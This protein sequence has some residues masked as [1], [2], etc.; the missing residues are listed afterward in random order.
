M[1]RSNYAPRRTCVRTRSSPKP[2][3]CLRKTAR[4]PKGLMF[5]PRPCPYVHKRSTGNTAIQVRNCCVVRVY[6]GRTAAIIIIRIFFFP[7]RY[8]TASTRSATV[9]ALI[10]YFCNTTLIS[11][12]RSSG[13]AV[14]GR[15]IR[16][17]VIV[18]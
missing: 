9:V 12:F 15:S 13:R 2:D 7:P 6:R 4:S 17:P 18:H 8:I 11:I 3:K 10:P 14:R 1:V 5:S 16:N